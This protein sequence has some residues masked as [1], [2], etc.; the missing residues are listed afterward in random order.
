MPITLELREDNHVLYG[1]LVDPLSALDMNN[2]V[3][4]QIPIYDSAVGKLH[5]LANVK[6]V[7]RLPSGILG[8]RRG[9]PV[10]NHPNRGQ[11]VLVGA[12]G[13]VRNIGEVL[14]KIARFDSVKF[15]DAEPEGWEYL[16]KVIADETQ[17]QR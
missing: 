1:V 14:M 6:G 4:E 2:S 16:R 15:F 5:Q 8:I 9:S 17:T 3:V 12:Q 11:L 7:T 13:F 10:F